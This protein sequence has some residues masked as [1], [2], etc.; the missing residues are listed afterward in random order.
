MNKIVRDDTIINWQSTMPVPISLH[1]SDK[2]H[3]TTNMMMQCDKRFN[4]VIYYYVM[5]PLD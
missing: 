2:L 3:C 4:S 1:F 5:Q